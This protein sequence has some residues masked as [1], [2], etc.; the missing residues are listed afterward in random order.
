MT[1]IVASTGAYNNDAERQD[2]MKKAGET[3]DAWLTNENNNSKN[4]AKNIFGDI[5]DDTAATFYL[6]DENNTPHELTKDSKVQF[7][8][9]A[10][11]EKLKI[12]GKKEKDNNHKPMTIPVPEVVGSDTTSY[13]DTFVSDLEAIA[14]GAD[15]TANLKKYLLA[16]IF[17]TRCH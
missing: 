4:D 13:I 8:I 16:S 10:T 2:G 17:L 9:G 14:A 1:N 12:D 11:G 5:F 6:I 15:A 7:A 3:L